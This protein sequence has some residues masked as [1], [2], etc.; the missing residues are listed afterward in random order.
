[1]PRKIR[2][3]FATEDFYPGFIGGQ[4][5]YGHH[6]VSELKRLG[7]GITVLAENRTNR[8][9]FWQNKVD[10]ILTPFCFGNQLC[11]AL[12]EYLLFIFKSNNYYDILHANQLSGLLFVLFKPPNI[13][14]IVV[15]V[16]NTYYEMSLRADGFK[17]WFYRPLI[18]L[19]RLVYERAD[20]LIFNTD[21]Q[22]LALG[23]YCQIK[24]ISEVI[25]L[26]VSQVAFT[27]KD[28]LEAKKW[29]RKKFNLKEEKV[30]LYVGRLVKRKKVDTLIKA[31]KLLEHQQVKGFII[32]MGSEKGALEDIAA[33]NTRFLGFVED[34]KPYF[35]SA[36]LFVTTSVAEGGIVLSAMEAAGFGLPL[37]LSKEAGEKILKD[38]VNGL[39]C[40]P[41][42]YMALAKKIRLVLENSTKMGEQSLKSAKSLS[43]EK[44]AKR[45]LNFY[46]SLQK[47]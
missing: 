3:C 28:R 46:L 31:L 40:G 5:I 26:G 23:S 30:V 33:E 2:I 1:M 34:T 11:L 35:L 47:P 8:R 21:S 15:S 20:G 9:K 45:T 44:C 22:K 32:G 4:G 17:K 42:D 6:L 18:W 10:L 13:G 36:D 41:D 14:K 25:P 27:K 19:E 16:H 24:N 12:L 29:L 38:G 43:W 7:V 39:Y 37:I